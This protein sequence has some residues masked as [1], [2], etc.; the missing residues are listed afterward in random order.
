[1]RRLVDEAQETLAQGSADEVA[2][3]AAATFPGRLAVACSMAGDTVVAQLLAR[4]APGVDVLFLD[5]GYHFPETLGTRLELARM[6]DA[7]IVDVRPAQS[8][9]QQDAAL[10]PKLYERDPELCCR[11]RKVEPINARLAGYE[12][13]VTGLRRQDGPTRAGIKTVEWDPAHQMVKINPLAA[14]SFD[15]LLDY[16]QRQAVPVNP[17]LSMGYPSIGCAPC[18]RPTAPG[19]DPRAGRWAGLLKTECGLHP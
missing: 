6:I 1:L 9:A 3:W 18:T 10:G 17:L 14:W 11:L 8:V 19:E 2:A 7:R 16:A 15:D 5:T 13:W 12:A 4:F